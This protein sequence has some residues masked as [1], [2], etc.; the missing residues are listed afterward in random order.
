M[1]LSKRPDPVRRQSS[2]IPSPS[3][4]SEFTTPSMFE[5]APRVPQNETGHV[6]PRPCSASAQAPDSSS[7][8]RPQTNPLASR[9]WKSTSDYIKASDYTEASEAQEPP[10]SES[11]FRRATLPVHSMPDNVNKTKTPSPPSETGD[12]RHATLPESGET[13]SSSP[14]MRSSAPTPGTTASSSKLSKSPS[15]E[16]QRHTSGFS[17]QCTPPLQELRA[18]Q[19]ELNK[20]MAIG[21]EMDQRHLQNLVSISKTFGRDEALNEVFK[22][23]R[24]RAAAKFTMGKAERLIL[25]REA[26]VVSRMTSGEPV[27][28]FEMR[29]DALQLEWQGVRE[30]SA[31]ARDALFERIYA[32]V[33]AS[34]V[35]VHDVLLGMKSGPLR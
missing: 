7:I 10:L 35:D 16:P 12:W 29:L 27:S 20:L 9:K 17:S 24:H 6:M 33:D 19:D 2:A 1:S 21:Y 22:S 4:L 5:A 25:E 11:V 13:T 34:L 30:A 18:I 15:P 3:G 28:G 32:L 31:R 14:I 26:D 23:L 8:V